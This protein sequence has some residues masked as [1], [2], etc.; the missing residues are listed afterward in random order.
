MP[1]SR[2]ASRERRSVATLPLPAERVAEHRE[3]LRR[4]LRA[5]CILRPDWGYSQAMNFSAAVA[6]VVADH[7]EATAFAIFVALVH[8]L[9]PDFFA[10]APP[11]RG[12]QV[13]LGAL[14]SL[15]E[16]RMPRLLE[17]RGRG[18]RQCARTRSCPAC[19]HL[20]SQRACTVCS[21]RATARCAMRCRSSRASG[22]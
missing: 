22:F 13:E 8:R 19:M 10:E 2:I 15:L 11:L 4:L 1:F 3:A 5:W 18:A 12:F 14:T 20:Y 21:R 6:L 7:D 16:E 17:A 9:P